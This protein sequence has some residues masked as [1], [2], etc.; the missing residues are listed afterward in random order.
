MSVASSPDFLFQ[1][2]DN[3]SK[4]LF[5]TSVD[6]NNYFNDVFN[7]DVYRIDD[8][9]GNKDQSDPFKDLFS[10]DTFNLSTKCRMRISVGKTCIVL[11]TTG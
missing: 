5:P 8:N 9:E 7:E 10:N 3:E 11:I 4:M 2:E 6:E 1:L